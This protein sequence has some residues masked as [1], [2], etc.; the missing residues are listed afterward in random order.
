MSDD[1]R[2]RI[3]DALRERALKAAEAK[4]I[5]VNS[6]MRLTID[7]EA[8]EGADAVMDIVQP[9]RKRLTEMMLTA[10]RQRDHQT[11][12][13]KKAEATVERLRAF[14]ES[15]REPGASL[16]W[17]EMG[18]RILVE[19]DDH[20]AGTGRC[21][22]CLHAVSLHQPDGCW[23][24]ATVGKLGHDLVCPCGQP[25]AALDQPEEDR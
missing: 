9:E 21:P 3:A 8:A 24:T 7:N 22:S 20:D 6:F 23:H 12:R 14:T 5:K 4:S 15:L 10:C 2:D 16:F 1:M 18:Q 25:R 13:A 17:P 19:I 11:G